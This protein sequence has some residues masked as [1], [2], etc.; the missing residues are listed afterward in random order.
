MGDW[1]WGGD[2][3]E[4]ESKNQEDETG[5]K[6]NSRRATEMLLGAKGL[7]PRAL[8]RTVQNAPGWGGTITHALA[9]SRGHG[10]GTSTWLLLA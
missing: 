3:R 6:K 8:L 1:N 7:R 9:G 10:L 2:S 5:R 4:Q